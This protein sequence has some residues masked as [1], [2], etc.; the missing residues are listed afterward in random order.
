[1]PDGP[2]VA[3]RLEVQKQ[4]GNS[5]ASKSNGTSGT[6]R[7][8]SWLNS[9]RGRAGPRSGLVSSLDVVKV[10]GATSVP[11]RETRAADS[12]PIWGN[13]KALAH[14]FFQSVNLIAPSPGRCL[15][16]MFFASLALLK[17]PQQHALLKTTFFWAP[18]PSWPMQQESEQKHEQLPLF[19][20]AAVAAL[21][22]PFFIRGCSQR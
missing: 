15:V 20:P 17:Q 22:M 5:S 4:M 16:G 3:P 18:F 10:P 19:R 6:L 9:C 11:S 1:M 8:I 14:L 12:S 7:A 2:L 13:D 21:L